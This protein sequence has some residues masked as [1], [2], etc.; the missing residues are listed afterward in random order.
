MGCLS[1]EN[2]QQSRFVHFNFQF[3][4]TPTPAS[5]SGEHE[6]VLLPQHFCNYPHHNRITK[7]LN[8]RDSGT[9]STFNA[10]RQTDTFFALLFL[11]AEQMLP[12]RGRG[13]GDPG[14]SQVSKDFHSLWQS[15]RCG[16]KENDDKNVSEET[17]ETNSLKIVHRNAFR[18]DRRPPFILTTTDDD[19]ALQKFF[20]LRKGSANSGKLC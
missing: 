5:L 10:R 17:F 3:T 12:F 7:S 11:L 9:P 4:P 16:G 6:N 2:I 1:V 13:V 19:V 20:D 8:S 18:T 14:V 15:A